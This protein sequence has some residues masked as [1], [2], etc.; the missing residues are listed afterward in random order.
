MGQAQAL[1]SQPRRAPA[2]CSSS[3]EPTRGSNLSTRMAPLCLR[4]DVHGVQHAAGSVSVVICVSGRDVG[5][6]VIGGGGGGGATHPISDANV[7]GDGLQP[8]EAIWSSTL[9]ALWACGEQGGGGGGTS[10]GRASRQWHSDLLRPGGAMRT[11]RI[12]ASDCLNP[13]SLNPKPLRLTPYA[14]GAGRLALTSPCL[15]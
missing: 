9:S 14:P 8:T 12:A 5:G 15:P 7:S 2:C 11:Q 4:A 3:S 6:G 1:L 13:L 10:T